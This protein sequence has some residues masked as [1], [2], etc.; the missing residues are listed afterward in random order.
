MIKKA[1]KNKGSLRKGVREVQKF[2][3]R[4]EKRIVI[5]AGDTSPINV[6]SHMPV[7][8]EDNQIP[9]VYVPSKDDLGAACGT[10]RPTC[11]LMVN[12]NDLFQEAYDEC[13]TEV[14]SLPL[15]T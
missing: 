3:R 8:C 14:K 5:L 2:I 4:G 6:F 11:M 1:S 15:P 9:Y 10:K 7:L 12:R 13:Y